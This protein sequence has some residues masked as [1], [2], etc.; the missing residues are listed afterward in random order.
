MSASPYAGLVSRLVALV[1]DGLVVALLVLMV[2]SLPELT[3][4]NLS[5][6]TVPPWLPTMTSVLAVTVP[7]LYFTAMWSTTGRTVGNLIMGI[8]VEHRDGHRLTVK[9]AFV[10]AGLGLLL[11]PFW[12]LGMLAILADRHRRAWHDQLLRTDVRYTHPR[13]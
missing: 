12:L 2:A 5:P 6:G 1:I 7:L 4:T 8:V 11:A 13:H 10:R 9:H 3:W